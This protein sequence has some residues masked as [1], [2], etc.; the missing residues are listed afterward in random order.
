MD[1]F[2]RDFQYGGRLW[3]SILAL[4]NKQLWKNEPKKK[5]THVRIFK[6]R[7]LKNL[8]LYKFLKIDN[9]L[10]N[11]I[12]PVHDTGLSIP[13]ENIRKPLVNLFL[14]GV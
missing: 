11:I 12:K 4:E 5:V 14:Q 1:N 7:W 6:A 9:N 13:S 10:V 8:N 2:E 3:I